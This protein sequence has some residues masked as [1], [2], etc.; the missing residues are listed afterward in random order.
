MKQ[1]LIDYR[2]SHKESRVLMSAVLGELDRISK[3]P[4]DAECIVV[5]KKMIE[6]NKECGNLEE[7]KIL[8]Q[9][10]PQQM[11]P[12][13]VIVILNKEQFPNLGLCMKYFKENYSGEYDSKM[14]SELYKNTEKWQ[15]NIKN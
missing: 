12:I 11:T 8:E 13:E 6:S 7:N 4:T 10:L 1:K 2:N 5:I 15:G 3:N 9:F 14:V